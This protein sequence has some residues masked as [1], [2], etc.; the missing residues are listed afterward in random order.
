M[1][2]TPS[3][4]L[5]EGDIIALL[6]EEG[7]GQGGYTWIEVFSERAIHL[8][9]FTNAIKCEFVLDIIDPLLYQSFVDRN[10][11]LD[12]PFKKFHRIIIFREFPTLLLPATFM[13]RG[14]ILDKGRCVFPGMR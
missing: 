10:S 7:V 11:E 4:L 3:N 5:C 6:I 13:M 12:V 8:K 14:S 1:R 2:R 9:L